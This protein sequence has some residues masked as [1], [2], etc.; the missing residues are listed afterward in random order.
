MIVLCTQTRQQQL[1][2]NKASE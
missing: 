1:V 2:T